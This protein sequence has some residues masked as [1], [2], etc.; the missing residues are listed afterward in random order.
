[1]L[2]SVN[3]SEK[4]AFNSNFNTFYDVKGESS[5][6][7]PKSKE[8][9]VNYFSFFIFNVYYLMHLHKKLATYY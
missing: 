7:L 9:S 2:A 6:F 3:F 5:S 1:M 4:S 8:L